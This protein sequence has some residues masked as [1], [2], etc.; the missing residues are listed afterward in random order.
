MDIPSLV[1]E[2]LQNAERHRASDIHLHQTPQGLSISFRLD[3]LLTEVKTLDLETGERV[4]GRIKYL[5]RLKTYQSSLPQDGRIEKAAS[6]TSQDIRVSTYPTV[7]G[8]KL[9]LRLFS[10]L[11]TPVFEELHFKPSV[12]E[13]LLQALRQPSG[14]ILLTGPAGSGKTST[15]Y[16]SL[17]F[18]SKNLKK[19]IVTIEDPVEQVI[20]GVTQT[21]VKELLGLTFASAA[22][23]VLRQDPEVLV[24]GEI[25]DEETARTAVRAALTG[26]LVI[27]TLHGGSCHG[28]IERLLNFDPDRHAIS[29]SLLL[30]INQRLLRSFCPHCHGSKCERCLH[31]GYLGRIPI[32]ELLHKSESLARYVQDRN[33]PIPELK[34]TLL[35]AG[36]DLVS[37]NKTSSVELSRVMGDPPQ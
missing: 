34:Q 14:L 10:G 12:T 18:L 37:Q 32:V 23:H 9:V 24:I 7:T 35:K 15:I 28:V 11:S 3:G 27:A 31:T 26:H 36:Q 4:I 22:K 2:L 21:E 13:T 30:I 17:S 16:A 6:G 33:A 5:A 20:P 25:R 8:E 29:Q 1:S 19:Q